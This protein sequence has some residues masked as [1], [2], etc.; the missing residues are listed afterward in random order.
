VTPR[1]IR[2][3]RAKRRL[4]KRGR[5]LP[6]VVSLRPAGLSRSRPD[7]IYRVFLPLI[8]RGRTYYTIRRTDLSSYFRYFH[9]FPRRATGKLRSSRFESLGARESR[10]QS[11]LRPT[12]MRNCVYPVG[13]DR[14]IVRDSSSG[15]C[16]SSG[17]GERQT[18]NTMVCDFGRATLNSI[19]LRRLTSKHARIDHQTRMHASL[20]IAALHATLSATLRES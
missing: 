12:Y 14:A 20:R 4:V 18:L 7:L 16:E 11:G 13:Y 3:S 1:A 5:H 6:L 9:F 19:E 2:K 17:V 8:G 10:A 15:V